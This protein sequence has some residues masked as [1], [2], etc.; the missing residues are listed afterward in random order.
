M[1]NKISK[2]DAEKQIK[3]FFKEI[4]NK[5]PQEIKKIKKLAMSKNIKL[6]DKRKLFCKKCYSP[7]L[8]TISIKNKTK[9]I[10]CLNCDNISRYRIK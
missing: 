5:S 1:K 7:L 2:K 3:E 6:K 4:K 9:K 10:K 8:K